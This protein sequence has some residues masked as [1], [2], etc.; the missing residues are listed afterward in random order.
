M[1]DALRRSPN[2]SYEIYS[3]AMR[4]RQAAMRNRKGAVRNYRAAIQNCKEANHSFKA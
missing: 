1:N 4:D 3:A 2:A